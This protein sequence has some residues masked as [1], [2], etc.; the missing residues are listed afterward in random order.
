[1]FKYDAAFWLK[2]TC[3]LLFGVHILQIHPFISDFYTSFL[4][5]QRVYSDNYNKSFKKVLRVPIKKTIAS[6]Q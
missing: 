4:E 5:D 1:M 2:E 3:T 6:L